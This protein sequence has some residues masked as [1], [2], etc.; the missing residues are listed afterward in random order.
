MR[1]PFALSARISGETVF[2]DDRAVDQMFLNDA[3]Q[4]RWCARVIPDAFGIDDRDWPVRADPQA[5]HLAPVNQRVRSEEIQFLEPPFQ[6]FPR[7]KSFLLRRALRLR[8][9][10]AQKNVAAIPLQSE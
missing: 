8:L 1:F 5:I 3:L 9:I 7:F 2:L 10:G 6:E 4:H